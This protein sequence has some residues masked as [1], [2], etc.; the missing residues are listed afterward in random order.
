MT[1]QFVL[2][3]FHFP[4]QWIFSFMKTI[5]DYKTTQQTHTTRLYLFT[6]FKLHLVSWFS[7]KYLRFLPPDVSD[8]CVL[9]LYYWFCSLFMYWKLKATHRLLTKNKLSTTRLSEQFDVG[10]GTEKAV[11]CSTTGAQPRAVSIIYEEC[12][13][14]VDFVRQVIFSL[15]Y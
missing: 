2:G 1:K 8:L 14:T 12:N 7:G 10:Q 15:F 6:V 11:Q 13:L 5:V 3:H 9:G 4:F